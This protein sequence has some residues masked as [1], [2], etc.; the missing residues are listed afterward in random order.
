VPTFLDG[1]DL[2]V[3]VAMFYPSAIAIAIAVPAGS[4]CKFV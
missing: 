3:L 1:N 4:T 2:K